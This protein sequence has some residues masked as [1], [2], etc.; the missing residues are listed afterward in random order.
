M[1]R[2]VLATAVVLGLAAPAGAVVAPF[3]PAQ[4]AGSWKG[5]WHNVTFGSTGAAFIRAKAI[6]KGNKAKLNFLSD[7]GGNVFG[8]AD[9]PADGVTLTKGAGAN[10]WGPAGFLIKGSSKAFGKLALTY[11]NARKTIAGSGSNPTCN[12]G[13]TWKVSGKFVGK[14]F[15]G[16]VNIHLPDGSNAVSK[17]ALKKS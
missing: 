14:T 11:N 2:V 8:C 10:H 5:T 9:P 15:N 12:P 6:G 17:I 7:F 1:R 13:L 4:I 16:T 3:Q